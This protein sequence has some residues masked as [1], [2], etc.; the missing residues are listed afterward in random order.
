[1]SDRTKKY[2]LIFLYVFFFLS[3]MTGLIYQIL[4]TKMLSLTFGHT[5]FAISSILSAFMGGLALGSYLIGRFVDR[6]SPG[7]KGG[8][9]IGK[10]LNAGSYSPYVRIYGILQLLIG[11]YILLT[12]SLINIVNKIYIGI[13]QNYSLGLY[14]LSLITF[15]LSILVFIFPTV[16]MGA[17]LP[18]ICKFVI[19]SYREIMSTTARLYSVNTFGAVLG[20]FLAGFVLFPVLG[21]QASLMVGVVINIG[22]GVIVILSDFLASKSSQKNEDEAQMIEEKSPGEESDDN[23]KK[24]DDSPALSD[25]EVIKAKSLYKLVLIVYFISGFTGMVYEVGW[26]RALAL[27]IGSSTYSFTII[28]T[29]FLFGIALGSYL[30]SNSKW[31]NPEK[32]TLL[33]LG[34]VELGIGLLGFLI[35]PTLGFLPFV[36]LKMFPVVSGSYTT[37][38]AGNF[39]LSFIVILLPTLLFGITF[40]MVVRIYTANLKSLGKSIGN[41][42]ASN[43]LG[44]ILGSFLAGFMFIPIFGA[45]ITLKIAIFLNLAAALIVYIFSGEKRKLS[46]S[47]TRYGMIVVLIILVFSL[48]IWKHSAM[49]L[50]VAVYAKNLSYVKSWQDYKDELNR[51]KRHIVF[52]KDGISSTVTVLKVKEQITLRVNGKADASWNKN[53]QGDI[54]T[55]WLLGFLPNALHPDPK[56]VCVIGFGS[57]MTVDSVNNFK[58]PELIDCVEIEP[59]VM[60]AS[61]HFNEAN[62]EVQKSPRVKIHIA[63]GRNF[64]EASKQKYDVIISEPSN[65]WIAGIGNLFSLDF[66][67]VCRER[68]EEDGIYA[69][70]FHSYSMSREDTQ[71]VFKTFFKAFPYGSV[72]FTGSGDFLL[73][74]KK[75]PSPVDYERIK[76]LFEKNEKIK[77][78]LKLLGLSKPYQ[79]LAYRITSAK[80]ARVFSLGANL[81]TDDHPLLEFNAPRNLYTISNHMAMLRTMLQYRTPIDE[82]VVNL[83]KDLMETGEFYK[84]VGVVYKKYHFFK[85]AREFFKKTATFPEYRYYGMFNVA[86]SDYAEKKYIKALDTLQQVVGLFPNRE[87]GYTFAI[88]VLEDKGVYDR[89][90]QY[91]QAGLERL[92]GNIEIL[93]KAADLAVRLKK[94]PLAKEYTEKLLLKEKDNAEYNLNMGKILLA[95]KEPGKAELFVAKSLKKKPGYKSALFEMGKIKME[96]GQY[97]VAEK[98]L[99][100]TINA[101]KNWVDPNILLARCYEK[102]GKK[103]LAIKQLKLII[104]GIDAENKPARE[105]L[106]RLENEEGKL[107][108]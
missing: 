72:W 19:K 59:A 58:E 32:V 44:G 13:M 85:V 75:K 105:Y 98:I 42:Y 70:W 92:P 84:Q 16:C 7:S 35:L 78:G 31:F 79:I 1:M 22:I 51:Q 71:M 74:G 49:S 5:V 10:L 81:N 11:L 27:S 21:L 3:G 65:P 26:S 67:K 8:G 14:P 102:L 6:L 77:D 38:L 56:R 46:A 39:I 48:K 64:I 17:T 104:A 15:F 82:N 63:D 12:P 53:V 28:L 62:H 68:L 107:P 66:Y 20:T 24:D 37:I 101:D 33:S 99:I 76:M 89:A 47:I 88:Q 41:V 106:F 43:T 94:Y 2:F 87:S 50:G 73:I 93:K 60:D 4:W 25:S 91:A 30:F 23:K 54:S 45:E 40:P 103:D 95:G 34:D 97:K 96:Q 9:F 52:Y 86:V 55:Q 80:Q 83:D 108:D 29:T 57:G 90:F 61:P 69:Q 18:V 100:S 36:F